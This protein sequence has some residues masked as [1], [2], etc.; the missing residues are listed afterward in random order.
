MDAA[1]VAKFNQQDALWMIVKNL[2]EGQEL[3][4]DLSIRD[5]AS[6]VGVSKPHI[7]VYRGRGLGAKVK[8]SDTQQELPNVVIIFKLRDDK[9]KVR[10]GPNLQENFEL[11]AEQHLKEQNNLVLLDRS[12]LKHLPRAPARST[13]T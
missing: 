10:T 4:Q 2:E 8:R 6:D 9:W 12:A 11:L 13:S 3:A 5:Q 7:P 1:L